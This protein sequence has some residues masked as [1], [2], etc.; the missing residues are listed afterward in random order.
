MFWFN[1][2]HPA[3]I[4]SDLKADVAPDIVQDFRKLSFPDKT[5][6]LV[7]FDPPHFFDK[8]SWLND[9]YG[10]LDIKEWPLQLREGFDECM[11]V[12]DDYGLLVFKW[13]QGSI[14]VSTVLAVLGQEPLFGH[15]SDKKART[16]WVVFMKFP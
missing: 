4:F 10:S 5:F 13:S 14:S 6:K 9:K 1:K 16:H 8:N 11:R 2:K 7:V 12:L 15:T 3:A